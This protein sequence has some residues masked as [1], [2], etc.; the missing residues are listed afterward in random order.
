MKKR[1]AIIL[2]GLILL[3]GCGP[4]SGPPIPAIV[5]GD[6]MAP[7]VCG[8]HLLVSC[9]ECQYEFKSERV[10]KANLKLTC[11]NCGYREIKVEEARVVGAAKVELVPFVR[12]PRRWDIVG[13]ELPAEAKSATGI[14]RIVSLPGETINIRDGDIYADDRI[15]RKSWELQK[16]VRIPVFDSKFNAITPFDNTNRFQF[17]NETFGWSVRDSELRFV[18][19]DEGPNWLEYIHWRNFLRNGDRNEEF[20][21]ED[22]YGFNQQT[23]RELNTTRDLMIELDVEFENDSTM[24]LQFQR[25]S[26]ELNFEITKSDKAFS[27]AWRGETQRKPLVYQSSLPHD[28]PGGLIEFSSFD[29]AVMLRINGTPV[30][31]LR[32]DETE[33]A[34]LVEVAR[35]KDV[36]RIGG[37][38][39]AFKVRRFRL[40]R[41]IHYL[42]A[43]A[44]FEPPAN[45]KLTAGSDEYIL[46]GDNSPKSL[47]SRTWKKP[48]IPRSKLIGR[49]VLP[50]EDN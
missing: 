25:G 49:L 37:G 47:D 40:W 30:F 41:D 31:E 23:V 5:E 3:T 4:K 44:G 13:F 1:N 36:F 42:T 38:K 14:K 46:L 33:P 21:I 27:L 24:M 45:L 50:L 22:S 48:G 16:E 28:L 15:L 39:G 18:S 34:G 8:E 12:F 26:S 32:E 6:S 43:P 10:A 20:P 19:G 11:P 9:V 29:R 2:L 7:T 17:A 35:A